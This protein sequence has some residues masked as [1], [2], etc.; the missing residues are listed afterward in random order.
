MAGEIRTALTLLKTSAESLRDTEP[1]E[2]ETHGAAAQ[3]YAAASVTAGQL[4]AALNEAC[5]AI[6]HLAY[7]ETQGDQ[8]PAPRS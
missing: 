3:Q 5:S 6:G 7:K 4:A 2:H 8:E 1:R